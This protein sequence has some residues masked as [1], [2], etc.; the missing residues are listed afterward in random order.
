MAHTHGNEEGKSQLSSWK[1]QKVLVP[2]N[3]GSK[4]KMQLKTKPS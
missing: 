1:M 2:E 4:L 3:P